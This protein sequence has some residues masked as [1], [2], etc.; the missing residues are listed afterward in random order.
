MNYCDI[1]T[2]GSD[3]MFEHEINELENLKDENDYL[4]LKGSVPILFF[5]S[6]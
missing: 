5:I 2:I 4:I 3:D 1:I 6:L